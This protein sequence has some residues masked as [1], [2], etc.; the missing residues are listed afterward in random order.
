MYEYWCDK[1]FSK[2]L[3]DKI[4]S[5]GTRMYSE[6]ELSR[7][8]DS[9][10]CIALSKLDERRLDVL[11]MKLGEKKT[12]K[13]IG[14]EPK[15]WLQRERHESE[16]ICHQ[17][18]WQLEQEAYQFIIATLLSMPNEALW[19]E[20]PLIATRCTSQVEIA[21]ALKSLTPGVISCLKKNGYVHIDELCSAT[22]KNLM[23]INGIGWSTIK[24]I[25]QAVLNF[26]RQNP[27]YFPYGNALKE[28]NILGKHA[29]K[30]VNKRSLFAETEEISDIDI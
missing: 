14:S 12:L 17:R 13:E 1:A 24:K 3:K 4:I 25:E 23:S 22:P 29:S 20:K 21:M 2:R 15:I 9:E 5:R 28:L 7:F 26:K 6:A 27:N 8:G 18:V 11:I 16:P 10:I 30:T 19:E